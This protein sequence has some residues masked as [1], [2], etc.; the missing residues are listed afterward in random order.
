MNCAYSPLPRIY[1][2]VYILIGYL[3][4]G[5]FRTFVCTSSKKNTLAQV[6]WGM[7]KKK[8]ILQ[9]VIEEE[10]DMERFQGDVTKLSMEENGSGIL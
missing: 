9:F 2:T 7:R 8:E 10:D 4:D 6:K 5:I 1:P 3:I